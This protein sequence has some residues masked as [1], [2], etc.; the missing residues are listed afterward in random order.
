VQSAVVDNV[1]SEVT[2]VP[3]VP[4]PVVEFE[5]EDLL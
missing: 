5:E 3:H 1:G 4:V 2:S